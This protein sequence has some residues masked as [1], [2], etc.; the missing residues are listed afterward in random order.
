MTSLIKSPL[1]MP[2][3]SIVN[4]LN[5]DIDNGEKA[6]CLYIAKLSNYPEFITLGYCELSAEK[7]ILSDKEIGAIKYITSKDDIILTKK[8]HVALKD[9]WLLEQFLLIQLKEYKVI[10]PELM[11]QR[12]KNYTET[13]KPPEVGEANFMDW[14]IEAVRKILINPYYGYELCLES[15]ITT[16]RQRQLYDKVQSNWDVEI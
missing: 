3:P 13:I 14:I 8:S 11:Q 4:W 5:D 9:C 15:L 1:F 12:W 10:V 16:T 6:S 7:D 2:E